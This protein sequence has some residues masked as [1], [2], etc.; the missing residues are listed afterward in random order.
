MK[1]IK[2]ILDEMLNVGKWK[3]SFLNVLIQTILSIPGRINFSSLS[4]YSGIPEKKF[5]RW[6]KKGFDFCVFNSLAIDQVVNDKSELIAAFDQ[7]FV[8]KSGK[9]TWGR[10]NF[11]NGCASK[12]E[13]GLELSLCALVDT[14]TNFAYS[15]FAEQTPPDDEIVLH[16]K[17]KNSQN[18]TRIDFYLSSIEKIKSVVLKYTKH[19]VFDGYFTKKKFVD[20]VVQMGFYVI[21]KLRRDANLK[22]LYKG[23]HLKKRGRPRKFVGKCNIAELEGFKFE[24][25]SN[26]ETKL[27]AGIF[28]H[29]SL[30]RNVKVVA[31]LQQKNNKIGAAL[32][33]STDLALDSFKIYSYYKARFQIE[34]VFRDANQYTGLGSCQSRNKKS[35]HF[36]FNIS[37]A[38]LNLVKIKEQLESDFHD[39]KCAFSM[40]SHKTRYYNKSMI[41]RFFPKLGLD[42]T[43]IKSMP[44]YQEMVNYGAIQSRRV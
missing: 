29:C 9:A 21:G 13:K 6:F 35:L 15:L 34:F 42:L 20:G 25:K 32:F 4:R 27:Y 28:Y 44:V 8:D 2:K 38:A 14:A 10:A 41:G 36:H 26:D 3:R 30:E 43:L 17:S 11:W 18:P 12:A 31:A 5:R 7:S 39:E 22:I 40:A 24:Q 19:F 33:F 16:T 37:F 23:S 1:L